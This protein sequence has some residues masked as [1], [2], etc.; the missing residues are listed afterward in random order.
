[1]PPPL[2][3]IQEQP[4][5]DD[6]ADGSH[7]DDPDVASEDEDIFPAAEFHHDADEGDEKEITV[8][9]APDP[10]LAEDVKLG[11]GTRV[12]AKGRLVHFSFRLQ[13]KIS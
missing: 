13:T 3:V 8:N 10:S 5:D 2:P 6:S 9:V 7:A 11:R 12:D 1:M 4:P